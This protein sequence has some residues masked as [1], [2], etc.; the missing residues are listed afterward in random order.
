MIQ[1]INKLYIVTIT[2]CMIHNITTRRRGGRLEVGVDDAAEAV[3]GVEPPQHVPHHP[4]H[5]PRR[6][7]PVPLVPASAPQLLMYGPKKL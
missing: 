1:I 6:Q 2:N 4:P 5:H 7:P 3:Q